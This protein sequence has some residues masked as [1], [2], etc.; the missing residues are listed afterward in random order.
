[1]RRRSKRETVALWSRRTGLTRLLE[2]LP[3]KRILLVL[4]YHRIGDAA[5]TAFDP[6]VFSATVED[7]DDQ[8]GFLARRFD[9]LSLAAVI[10]IAEGRRTLTRP[11]VLLTFDDGY[12]D[13]YE[14]A[15]PVLRKH[16]VHGVFFLPT[17]FIGTDRIPWWD[18]IAYT[19]KHTER[20]RFALT[21]PEP[22]NF[23]VAAE[24][25]DR[26]T[27]R[28][29]EFYK[30]PQTDSGRFLAEVA[31][32]CNCAPISE[33]LFMNW[34]E[35]RQIHEGGMTLG[36][37]THTHEILSKLSEHDQFNELALSR[38][39]IEDNTGAEVTAFAY[40]VGLPN[41]FNDASRRALERAGYRVAFSFYGGVNH[42]VIDR[43]NVLRS[44]VYQTSLNRFRLDTNVAAV[45]GGMPA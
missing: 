11:S 4:N 7:F 16:G 1:M 10:D 21:Y 18:T 5:A 33:R 29:L 19:V 8:V 3:A 37:H 17:S 14:L 12:I 40:P 23:D 6:Q 39:L 24:G 36:S 28:L 26:V 38:R 41:C 43:Y 9:A 45:T 35:A 32:V 25:T 20:R 31:D 30:R 44:T 2:C 15:F 34:H 13:N 27:G 42:S 22:A